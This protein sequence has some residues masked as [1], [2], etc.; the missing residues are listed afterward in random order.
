MRAALCRIGAAGQSLKHIM[1][2]EGF[3]CCD[4]INIQRAHQV[5]YELMRTG[6]YVSIILMSHLDT[7]REISQKTIHIV[8]DEGRFSYIRYGANADLGKYVKAARAS[9]DTTIDTSKKARGR[10][11]KAK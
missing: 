9:S 10:P 7:V 4:S 11:S 8:R 6:K 5:V 1:I 3:G 2:D